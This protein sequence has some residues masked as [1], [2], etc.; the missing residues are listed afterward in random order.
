MSAEEYLHT[1]FAG[2]DPEFRDG[3][4]V[5]R[6]IPDYL[7]GKTQALLIALF[8]ALRK[9]LSLYPCA[10]TRMMVRP[11]R[12]LIPDVAVFHPDE[13]GLVP[14]APPLIAIEILSPDDRLLEVRAKLEEYRAWGV[15][16]AWLVD[17]QSRRLYSCDHGLHEVSRLREDRLGMSEIAVEI[18]PE[19]IFE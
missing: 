15:P 12:F 9:S 13:P 3:T 10:E 8:M 11:G 2:V 1:S 4:F 6:S 18:T 19:Q 7:H 14:S 17:P 5:E 16:H